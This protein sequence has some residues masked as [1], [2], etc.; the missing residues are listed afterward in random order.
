[1]RDSQ[2]GGWSTLLVSCNFSAAPV[3]SQASELA[4]GRRSQKERDTG[5][6]SLVGGVVD[7]LE[8]VSH[9]VGQSDILILVHSDLKCVWVLS[10]GKSNADVVVETGWGNR[11]GIL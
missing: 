3:A 8:P 6:E 1:M 5:E 10:R 4:S 11:S 9:G 7:K 2:L